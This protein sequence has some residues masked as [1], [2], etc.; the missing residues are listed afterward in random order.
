MP[1]SSFAYGLEK[2]GNLEFLNKADELADYYS[3]T[4][5]LLSKVQGMGLGFLPTQLALLADLQ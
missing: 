4:G 5:T 3:T 1:W 2:T